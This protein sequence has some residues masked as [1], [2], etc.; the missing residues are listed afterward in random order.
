MGKELQKLT[1]TQL[2]DEDL[3]TMC[4]EIFMWKHETGIL[5][6]DSKLRSFAAKVRVKPRIAEEIVLNE[7]N[8]RFRKMVILL[9]QNG[10]IHL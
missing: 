4:D 3:R 7:A 10:L 9:M 8:K 6:L 2:P 1:V 5:P